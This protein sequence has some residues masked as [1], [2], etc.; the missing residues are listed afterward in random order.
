MNLLIRALIFT[1]FL[2]S[3]S[4]HAIDGFI[5]SFGKGIDDTLVQS[6]STNGANQISAGL[7]FD[8]ELSFAHP[9]VGFA[10]NHYEFY[11]SQ[12]SHQQTINIVALRPTFTFWPTPEKKSRW[13]WQAGLGLAMF[14]ER[15]FGEIEL[16][17]NWQFNTMLGIGRMIDKNHQHSL[18]LRYN[19]YSNA[20]IKTPNPG[21]DTISLDWVSRL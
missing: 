6:R 15:N 7:T 2:V 4:A 10:Q 19:H 12:I 21:I 16:S 14:N 8:S 20:Y 1:G 17:T 11:L 13:F 18:T 5:L 9:L 3:F